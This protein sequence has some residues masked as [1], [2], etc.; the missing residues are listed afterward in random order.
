MFVCMFLAFIL[1]IVSFE[2]VV[3]I[4][5]F[6]QHRLTIG[7]IIFDNVTK[8]RS[9]YLHLSKKVIPKKKIQT[10]WSKKKKWSM[11]YTPKIGAKRPTIWNGISIFV[12]IIGPFQHSEQNGQ[13]STLRTYTYAC[14]TA[15]SRHWGEQLHADVGRSI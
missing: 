12:F 3:S 10:C 8:L 6:Y 7:Y 1:Y 9:R 2:C 4:M 13:C 11:L 15:P 14:A 5:C